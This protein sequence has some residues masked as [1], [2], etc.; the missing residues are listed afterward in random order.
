MSDNNSGDRVLKYKSLE[1]RNITPGEVVKLGLSAGA[2]LF[3]MW[4]L[5]TKDGRKNVV[6][7]A[8]KIVRRLRR[9]RKKIV[10]GLD[11]H[12]MSGLHRIFGRGALKLFSLFIKSTKLPIFK[13]TF[14]KNR[15]VEK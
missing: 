13:D 15:E 1:L 6:K 3:F 14:Y 2:A 10:T 7:A 8:K 11:A 9:G 4:A 12:A 5:G